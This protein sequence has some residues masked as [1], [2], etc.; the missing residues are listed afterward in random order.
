MKSFPALDIF[1]IYN[2]TS[3][4]LIHGVFENIFASPLVKC[5]IENFGYRF[6]QPFFNRV[7]QL[8]S[9][10]SDCLLIFRMVIRPCTQPQRWVAKSLSVFCQSA[11]VNLTRLAKPSIFSVKQ[12]WTQPTGKTTGKQRRSSD[13]R[14]IFSPMTTIWPRAAAPPKLGI[15]LAVAEETRQIEGQRKKPG[16][17]VGS[18]K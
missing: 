1:S 17:H 2:Q 4:L 6:G 18:Q 16:S 3:W 13:T 8:Q 5:C 15:E 11:Q 9:L 7:S 12:L 10:K 14:S